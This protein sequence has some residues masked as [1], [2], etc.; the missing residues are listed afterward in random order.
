MNNTSKMMSQDE[1]NAS[2][3]RA[4]K[5]LMLAES[6]YGLFLMQLNK[7]WTDQID[8]SGVKK[9]G[10]NYQIGINPLFWE[11]LTHLWRLMVL[12]AD[13][14]AVVFH[15]I[16]ISGDL[17]DKELVSIAHM[18]VATQYIDPAWL[19]LYDVNYRDFKA[20][21]EELWE[22][23][24]AD[25]SS[26]KKTREQVV[27]ELRKVP[28]RGVYLHDFP[29]LKLEEKKG[30]K[31]YYDK[32]QQAKGKQPGKGGSEALNDLL[33]NKDDG[34][35]ENWMKDWKEF[36][37]LSEAEKKL[38]RSQTDFQLKEVAEQIKKSRGTIPSEMEEYI[39]SLD[40]SEPPKF[41]W[42]AYLRR[43]VGGSEKVD[44][45][46][47][48]AKPNLR[49]PQNPGRRLRSKAKIMV[50]V[51]TSG[52]MTKSDLQT[53]FHEIYHMHKMG[54]DVDVV[55]F[56]AAVQNVESYKRGYEDTIRLVGRGGTDFTPA[57]QYY[58]DHMHKY[59]CCIVLT[60]GACPKPD[61]QKGR[62]LWV[63]TPGNTNVDLQPQIVLN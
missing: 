11:S 15:H 12:K 34:L 8:T 1:L 4:T 31:Y 52:S 14:L 9:N 33:K 50:A 17:P 56:D 42:R 20:L 18:I 13:V 36:Q 63:I 2:L 10:I 44:V 61:N 19:P 57:L 25:L 46:R 32:L 40:K 53:V 59:A 21:N 16:E 43:F 24:K 37:G 54:T 47:S 58:N 23:L 60:D 3:S 41:N 29:E 26:G 48:R 51:D 28:P 5:G 55:Q 35:P 6:F 45:L 49:Y 39:N 30:L 7:E 27:E 22:L 38:L 62:V